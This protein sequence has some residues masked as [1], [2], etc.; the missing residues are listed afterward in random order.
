MKAIFQ[1]V[2]AKGGYDLS[3]L[4]QK[5]DIYHIEGKLSDADRDELYAAARKA[6]VAQYDYRDEIEKLWAAVRQL[7]EAGKSDVTDEPENGDTYPA[8][9]QPTGAHDAYQVGD[10]V[11][12]NGQRY[13]CQLANCVWSP[14]VLPSAWEVIKEEEETV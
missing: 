12:Y 6:P 9:V 11:T 13:R 8:F 10:L 4:L 3:A 5:I 2:I 1:N 7:Q 14:D